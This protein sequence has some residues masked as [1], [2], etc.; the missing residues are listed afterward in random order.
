MIPSF[1]ESIPYKNMWSSACLEAQE[2]VLLL[3]LL[4]VFDTELGHSLEAQENVLL[5]ILLPVFDT[6]SFIVL[7]YLPYSSRVGYSSAQV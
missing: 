3:I 4:P 6:G 1:T 2:N 7:L 5:L